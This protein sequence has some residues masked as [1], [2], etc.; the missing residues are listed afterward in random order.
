MDHVSKSTENL[1]TYPNTSDHL[2]F[3]KKLSV[4]RSVKIH[5]HFNAYFIYICR[6]K[7]VI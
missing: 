3:L 2:M 6:V 7:A 4:H 5:L 1:F